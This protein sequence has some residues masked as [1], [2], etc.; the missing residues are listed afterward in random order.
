MQFCDH[1][2]EHIYNFRM[3]VK[4]D[5]RE[6]IKLEVN[7]EELAVE[8]LEML[9]RRCSEIF[10]VVLT[11]SRVAEDLAEDR[12][13]LGDSERV[14]SLK[15]CPLW[16]VTFFCSTLLRFSTN[17]LNGG[18]IEIRCSSLPTYSALKMCNNCHF[19]HLLLAG[20]HSLKLLPLHKS[21]VQAEKSLF[22][23]H[24]EDTAW[25][26]YYVTYFKSEMFRLCAKC[27]V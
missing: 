8:T 11:L 2:H 20:F 21:K 15:I 3:D 7:F 12:R 13:R 5:L 22:R 19:K 23:H 27:W 14:G 18:V 17:N 26:S 6:T 4:F 9:K 10:Q 1:V 24:G 16:S 25:F